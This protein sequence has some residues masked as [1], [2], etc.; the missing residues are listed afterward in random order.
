[1]VW[2]AREAEGPAHFLAV[3]WT[4]PAPH[5]LDVALRDVLGESAVAA[6][7]TWTAHDLWDPG[8]VGVRPDLTLTLDVPAHGVRWLELTRS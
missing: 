1:V 6:G 2:S 5:R 8:V 4:G 7:G 3:T